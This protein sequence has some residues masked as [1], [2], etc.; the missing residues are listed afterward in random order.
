MPVSGN[1]TTSKLIKFH[2]DLNYPRSQL[3]RTTETKICFVLR[4]IIK[5]TIFGCKIVEFSKIF[6]R[7]RSFYLQNEFAKPSTFVS[8]ELGLIAD[9]EYSYQQAFDFWEQILIE[10]VLKERG[11]LD[12]Q[13]DIEPTHHNVVYKNASV[14]FCSQLILFLGLVFN[15]ECLYHI[16]QNV[17]LNLGGREHR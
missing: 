12:L 10:D 1:F 15:K 3:F 8:F 2:D 16:S 9:G 14:L 7:R 11:I 13:V 6:D 17:F 5:G 4:T